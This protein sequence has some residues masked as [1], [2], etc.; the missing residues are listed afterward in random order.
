MLLKLS[1]DIESN[2]RIRTR[3]RNGH[4]VDQVDSH[5]VVINIGRKFLRDSMT[6]SLYP[7]SSLTPPPST[8]SVAGIVRRSN[9]M[10]RYVALGAGGALQ[11]AVYPGVGTFTEVVTVR[12][13]E[14]PLPV[15]YR[16]DPTLVGLSADDNWQW[17]KQVEPQDS[18]DELP[19]DFSVIYRAVFGYNEISFSGQIGDYG[20]SVPISEVLLLTSEAEAYIRAPMASNAYSVTHATGTAYSWPPS[21]SPSFVGYGGDVDGAVAYNLTSPIYKTPSVTLE[22]LWELRS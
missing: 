6:A 20:T 17:V 4:I 5:N 3:D 21:S 16:A 11:T 14:R 9:E 1:Q 10:I 13:L 2:V 8:P 15:T 12:G 7:I 18:A 22:I 19:D